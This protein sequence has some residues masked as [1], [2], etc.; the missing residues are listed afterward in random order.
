MQQRLIRLIEGIFPALLAFAALSVERYLGAW[1]RDR[2]AFLPL[3]M[4]LIGTS[5]LHPRL[6]RMFIISLCY[7]VAFLALRDSTNVS[8]WQLPFRLDPD[9]AETLV[10]AALLLVAILAGI[11]A[12]AETFTP[13]TIWARRCYFGAAALYFTGL[14]VA[15]FGARGSWQAVVL[16]ITGITA[17]LG[18]I[19]A[20]RMVDSDPVEESQRIDNDEAM[21]RVRDDEHRRAIRDK[22]WQDPDLNE[23]SSA[24][25]QGTT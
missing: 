7:G 4:L 19:F 18:C 12:I 9:V 24:K 10:L 25:T 21:Q 20:D 23:A 5:L 8:R 22:E 13:D 15:G 1:T 17:L 11:A 3:I 6:R 14:G 16:C 2:V